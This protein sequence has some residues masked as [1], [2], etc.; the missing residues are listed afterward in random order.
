MLRKGRN[1]NAVFI[2]SSFEKG[3]PEMYFL[4]N[5]I[6]KY[7]NKTTQTSFQIYI[8]E[9]FRNILQNEMQNYTLFILR[10]RCTF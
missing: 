1:D 6:L 9:I 2:V 7:Q 10:R 8:Q 3:K 4:E 5:S